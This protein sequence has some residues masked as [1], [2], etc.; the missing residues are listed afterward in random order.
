MVKIYLEPEDIKPADARKI[1]AF[2]NAAQTPE[3]IATAVEIAEE[4]DVGVRIARRILERHRALGVFTDLR[5]VT[6]VPL[7]GPERFTEIVTTLSGA[8]PPRNLVQVEDRA[9][10]LREIRE[11][12]GLVEELG[13]TLKHQGHRITLRA[14]QERPFLGQSVNLLAR[15]T[16]LQGQPRIDMPVILTTTWGRLRTRQGLTIQ[17]G[18]AVVAP[19]DGSGAARA[20][21]LPPTAED[22]TQIQQDT[23]ETALQLL[24]PAAVTPQE[25]E[26]GLR[27]LARQYRWD[28]NFELRRAVDIYFRDFGQRLLDAV[29]SSDVTLAWRSFDAAMLAYAPDEGAGVQATAALPVRFRDWLD[30]W[31]S[32]YRRLAESESRLA[33]DLMDARQ[34]STEAGALVGRVYRR[35]REYVTDQPGRVGEVIGQR[36]AE[37]QLRDF[38]DAA[39]ADLPSDAQIALYPALET[40]SR[41]V[42]TAGAVVLAAVGQTRT[43]L[44]REIGDRVGKLDVGSLTDRVATL[45]A[46]I[47]QKMDTVTFGQFQDQ[48][49]SQLDLKLDAT[50]FN[51]FQTR[52]NNELSNL[53]T[54]STRLNRDFDGLR[55]SVNRLNSDVTVLKDRLGPG[56]IEP[57]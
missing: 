34:R 26:E 27:E 38:L 13:A 55:T 28:G 17:E 40:A 30:P 8:R 49:N 15:V 24:D 23:L 12:R 52:I 29:N 50:T 42:G 21:L 32:I 33:Q 4:R 7:V 48:I 56:R 43:E 57:R 31:L 6:D 1:L 47:D 3:E 53:Q 41:T 45:E 22:L 51:G 36:I 20:L 11:L 19:T 18:R 10:L 2:L 25:A 46:Q 16:D 9:D 5:Q 39:T 54:T 37:T 35:V 44:R 14:L